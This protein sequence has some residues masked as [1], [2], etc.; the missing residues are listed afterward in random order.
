[1]K[2]K[3][4]K[5]DL[6]LLVA[7]DT[8]MTERGVTRAGRTLGITQAAMSN[9]LRRLR[10]LF[11]DPLFVKVGQRMEPTARA[12]ELA[13]PVERALE[14]VRS[15]LHQER[16]DPSES[17]QLFR[18]GMVDYASAMLLP[19]MLAHLDQIAP[20]V[21]IEVLDPGGHD[22]VAM[23]ESGGADL[24]LSRFQWVPPKV[25][26]HRLFQMDYVCIF[27]QDHPL[28]P[29]NAPLTLEAFLAARHVHYYPRGMENTAVDE[30]LTQMGLERRI[31]GRLHSLVMVPYL[32]AESDLMAIV[33][34]ATAWYI[35]PPLK[36]RVEPIPIKQ[37]KL[38]MAMAW[39]PRTD[40]SPAHIWL[41][42]EVKTILE[43]VA[44][45]SGRMIGWTTD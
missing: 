5:V 27:R 41:R 31:P 8:L 1:M 37:P 12:L 32:L 16:F 26:I 6:N 19:R 29:G 39:H 20:G 43:G 30:A 4:A 11:D 21:S 25:L 24:V 3:L 28:V 2:H 15:A 34:A 44:H 22:E 13:G 10:E 23:L 35:A 9:T 18:I 45:D 33:P 38:R 42:E 14:Q 36:L 17:R 40:K 7:F